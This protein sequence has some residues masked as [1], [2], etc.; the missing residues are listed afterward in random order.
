MTTATAPRK[1]DVQKPVPVPNGDFYQLVEVLAPDEMALVKKVRTYMETNVKP[2][3]N[4]YWADDAFP[5]EL[6]SSFKELGL[7]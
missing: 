6:L 3:I 2:V 7:S 4:K 5:F 1:T